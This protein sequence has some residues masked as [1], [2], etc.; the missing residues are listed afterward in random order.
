MLRGFFVS[1]RLCASVSHAKIPWRHVR[2]LF[3]SLRSSLY[4]RDPEQTSLRAECSLDELRRVLGEVH[5]TNA[6]ELSY[7]K[8]EDLNMRR[9]EYRDDEWEWYQTHVRGYERDGGVE[10]AVHTELEPSEYPTQHLHN[11]NFTRDEG[12][13][14]IESIL[15]L[16]GVSAKRIEEDEEEDESSGE[17]IYV[18]TDEEDEDDGEDEEGISGNL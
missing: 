14:A 18:G 10:I 6:W 2:L 1:S 13:Q 15:T 5:F 7:D 16:A 3:W 9:P 4:R 12:I 11:V 8:G 17:T